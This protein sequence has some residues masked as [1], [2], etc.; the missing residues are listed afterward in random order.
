MQAAVA[1]SSLALCAHLLRYV[2]GGG[3]A[4]ETAYPSSLGPDEHQLVAVVGCASVLRDGLP[5]SR[6]WACA[7]LL[8]PCSYRLEV[9]VTSNA[10][11]TA[12]AHPAFA[13]A[14]SGQGVGRGWASSVWLGRTICEV[15]ASPPKL[16]ASFLLLGSSCC[17][18]FVGV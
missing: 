11:G 6:R 9:G 7:L 10:L 16:F 2:L 14:R 18:Y 1:R 13:S 4:A 17:S 3:G 5:L 12:F 15:V 8:E